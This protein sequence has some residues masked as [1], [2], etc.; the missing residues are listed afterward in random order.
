MNFN[1]MRLAS[2]IAAGFAALVCSQPA[3]AQSDHTFLSVHGVDSPTCG[4]IDSPCGT[5]NQAIANTNPYG[6]VVALDSGVYVNTGIKISKSI[7]LTAAPSAHVELHGV[8]INGDD[9]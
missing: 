8:G 4:A 5:F 2:M 1:R 6:E 9:L 7:T 3:S